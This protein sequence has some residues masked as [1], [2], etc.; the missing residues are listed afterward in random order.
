M[1]PRYSRPDMARIWS[2]ESKF[3][4]WLD[5]EI[6]VCEAWAEL[7]KIPKKDLANIKARAS[8]DINRILEIEEETK[9]DVIAFLTAVAEKVGPSSRYIHMGMT[10]YDVVDTAFSLQL[11]D[12][13]NIIINDIQKL[14]AVLKKKAMRYKKTPIMGRS[15]GIHAEPT[16]FGL[17]MAL[18]YEEF[19]RNLERMK[20]ARDAVSVGKISGAVGTYA[21]IPPEIE[22]KV[23]K[24][25]G[26]KPD[27]ISTQIIQR[28]RHAEF[29]AALAIIASSVEKL[30]VEIRHL[31]RTEVGEV[32]E[33]FT[34]GQKGSSA[35]PHKRNPILS[36]NISGLARVVR[37]NSLAAM[38]NVAL[39]HERDI[40]HSS[41][42]RVIGPDSTILVDFMLA[43]LTRLLDGLVVYP[44][45][46]MENIEKTGGLTF[47]QQV[48]LALIDKGITREEAYE[49]V[50]RNAMKVLRLGKGFKDLLLKD[51]DV[52]RFLKPAEITKLFDIKYHLKYVDKVFDRIFH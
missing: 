33:P 21:N 40:S 11:R 50:Q 48:L 42:E 38:E 34:K 43:R 28:D 4:Y 29:F 8:F 23:C 26:L 27:K 9:H 37:A 39:W 31:Q 52:K 49:I 45:R 35:M 16:T 32:E 14:L 15:H 19:V 20:T 6:A 1:I 7:G 18:F 36:E 5:V 13:S 47:S 51:R 3:G 12:A 10:S 30:A 2:D 17:K 24:R 22:I 25:L 41:V 46:M 44:Q